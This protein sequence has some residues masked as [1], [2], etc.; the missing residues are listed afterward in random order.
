MTGRVTAVILSFACALGV[1]APLAHAAPADTT[2]ARVAA[3]D[4]VLG[5]NLP[6]AL[7]ALDSARAAASRDR[8]DDAIRLYHRAIALYAP[9]ADDL[10][11]ELGN[12]YTWSGNLDSAMTWYRRHL[13]HHPGDVGAR[14]GIARLTGWKD[15]HGRAETLYN[16]ILA[17]DP[18]NV[19]ALLGRAQVV[20][21]SGRHREASRLY[22]DVL[23][24]DPDNVWAREGLARAYQWGGRPDWAREVASGNE[25]TPPVASV[26]RDLDGSRAPR[27]SYTF[28]RN[29]DSDEIERE[30]HTARAGVGV[31]DMTSLSG[32]YG[33]ARYQQPLFPDVSRDW[34]AAIIER[35]FSERASL[36]A[37]AGHQWNS[38]DRSALG[39]QTYWQDE[40]NLFTFDGYVTVMPRDWTRID[41]GL[42]HG[43]LQNPE[44][45]F[46]G[47]SLT[48][49][50]L[51]VDQRLNTNTLWASELEAAWYSD[52]NSRV[53]FG[54]R[55][56][57]Q[58]LW[59]LPIGLDHRFTS[60]TGF[61]AFGFDET[62]DNGYYDPRQYLSFYEELGVEMEF[63][64][65]LRATLSG[66]LALEKENGSDWF[67]AGSVSASASWSMW[68]GLGITAGVYSSESRLTSREGYQADGF[69]ITVD[70]RHDR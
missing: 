2:S 61:G 15:D 18:G 37:A 62:K 66:R 47:I 40:F 44:T 11:A 7:A 41:V 34:I 36:T 3:P 45:I 12:Q 21:W 39:P 33:H 65:R 8:H 16:E 26:I 24:R 48:E 35:R 51:G 28:D 63:S 27:A 60:T 14:L 67:T 1:H 25:S 64:E 70:Y 13:E 59:R 4:P 42:F 10:G 56:A 43:S 55:I 57:W 31:D 6:R 29:E 52:V 50:S 49:V 17:D 5:E 9:L 20:N 22:L 38:F 32:E 68:R 58:P 54:T 69:Y 30:T 23:E 46:R 19:D 53:G